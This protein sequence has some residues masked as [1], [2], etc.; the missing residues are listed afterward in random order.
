MTLFVRTS[1]QN[2]F[3]SKSHH[4]EY[5]IA[6]FPRAIIINYGEITNVF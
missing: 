1:Y 4:A 3:I 6:K 2:K 5:I